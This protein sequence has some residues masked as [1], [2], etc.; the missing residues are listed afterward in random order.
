APINSVAVPFTVA[1]NTMVDDPKS[2]S[3]AVRSARGTSQRPRTLRFA[4][5]S[6]TSEYA[7]PGVLPGPD[8]VDAYTPVGVAATL[9]QTPA[10]M[11]P[12]GTP[13]HVA[14]RAPVD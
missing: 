14:I 5:S 12:I 13:Y 2:A 11:E 3:P 10:P 9:D 4:G 8:A 1:L 7:S 6:L